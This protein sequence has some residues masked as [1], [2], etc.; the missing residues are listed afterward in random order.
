VKKQDVPS[1]GAGIAL[2]ATTLHHTKGWSIRS[3]EPY[4]SRSI[5]L[6]AVPESAVAWIYLAG[7]DTDRFL[8]WIITVPESRETLEI[9]TA[10]IALLLALYLRNRA[11]QIFHCIALS[12]T[13]KLFNN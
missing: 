13:P 7:M 10:L 8:T 3:T 12:Q 2:S 5:H 6:G 11:F 9:S 1:N 4:N